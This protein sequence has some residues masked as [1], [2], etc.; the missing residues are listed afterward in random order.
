MLNARTPRSS[1]CAPHFESVHP[2]CC[3]RTGTRRHLTPVALKTA[4]L[5]LIAARAGLTADARVTAAASLFL[6]AASRVLTAASL[7]PAAAPLMPIA[8]R[9]V[10]EAD[11]LQQFLQFVLLPPNEKSEQRSDSGTSARAHQRT[12]QRGMTPHRSVSNAVGGLRR[13]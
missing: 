13:S 5:F 8:A 4:D 12:E 1:C 7:H 10:G 11:P 2:S 6:T 9:V 3:W